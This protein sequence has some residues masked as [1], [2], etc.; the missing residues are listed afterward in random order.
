MARN[1]SIVLALE[2]ERIAQV[3]RTAYFHEAL[4]QARERLAKL[5]KCGRVSDVR[6]SQYEDIAYVEYSLRLEEQTFGQAQ[7]FVEAIETQLYEP[8]HQPVLFVCHASDDKVFAEQ[9]V[10]ALDRNALYAWF[11]KRE[12]FV[13]ESIVAKIE[14]ALGQVRYVIAVLSRSSVVKPWVKREL[15]STMMRQLE[16]KGV[17]VLPALLDD[18]EIPPLLADVKYA[19]FRDSF[20]VGY[21]DLLSA[22]R[23]CPR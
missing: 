7:E 6:D 12:V 20:D 8:M 1:T 4:S 16:G 11:D 23:R 14:E 9:L 10:S 21:K 17:H 2:D 19:D 18:C 3:D 13:G 5:E 22:I 15:H